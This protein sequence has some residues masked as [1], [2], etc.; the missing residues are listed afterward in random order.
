LFNPSD[1]EFREKVK[2]HHGWGL[3]VEDLP[4]ADKCI[5]CGRCEKSCTQHL[6]IIERLKEFEKIEKEE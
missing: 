6:P 3:L 4:R 2:F 5:A 1:E